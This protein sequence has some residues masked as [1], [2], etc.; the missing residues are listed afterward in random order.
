LKRDVHRHGHR[1]LPAIPVTK[2]RAPLKLLQDETD[3]HARLAIPVTDDGA[4]LK[5][6]WFAH[7]TIEKAADPRRGGQALV[8]AAGATRLRV[9]RYIHPRHRR[10]GPR[11]SSGAATQH[12]AGLVRPPSRRTGPIEASSPST[13]PAVSCHSIPSPSA[14]SG[15]ASSSPPTSPSPNGSR[16]SPEACERSLYLPGQTFPE[17]A[18]RPTAAAL[19]PLAF[20]RSTCALT[21]T[22]ARLTGVDPR[23]AGR[24]TPG[25]CGSAAQAGQQ[26]VAEGQPLRFGTSVGRKIGKSPAFVIVGAVFSLAYPDLVFQLAPSVSCLAPKKKCLITNLEPTWPHPFILPSAF[27]SGTFN[28]M[29][30]MSPSDDRMLHTS[31]N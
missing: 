7:D 13:A 30:S 4:P 12:L 22:R 25:G 18:G 23:A 16:S 20:M 10:T 3:G 27:R 15:G 14:T 8:E 11:W 1:A 24:R 29:H 5:H 6:V 17:M 28:P 21:T 26:G 9:A 19:A 31:A 2:D